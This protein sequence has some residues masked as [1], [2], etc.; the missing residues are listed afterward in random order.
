MNEDYQEAARRVLIPEAAA[1]YIAGDM[2]A[3]DDAGH[4]LIA[5]EVSKITAE[6]CEPGSIAGKQADFLEWHGYEAPPALVA[7][8]EA[9]TMVLP[10]VPALA[11]EF[12]RLMREAVSPKELDLA[13]HR[14]HM[15]TYAYF[16]CCATHDFTDSNVLM[17]E[18]FAVLGY[19][20]APPDGASLDVATDA[21]SATWNA[22]WDLAKQEG[23]RL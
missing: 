16:G 18:A 20:T 5:N 11:K 7:A 6:R 22:A 8:W 15:D 14:N 4:D 12:S 21:Y 9:G 10:E 3:T 23:F 17:S 2:D 1:R 19:D 13:N